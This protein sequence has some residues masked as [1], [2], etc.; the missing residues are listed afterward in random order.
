M[1]NEP[2]KL[3]GQVNSV[4]GSVEA[5]AGAV[6]EA[7]FQAVGG[8]TEP[9]V[10]TKDGK[11]R[12]D[13]GE[14]EIKAAEAKQYAEGTVDRVVGKKDAIV[15]AITG[16]SAQELSGNAQKESGHAQQKLATS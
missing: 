13:K 12:H 7:G 15:G 14:A 16:D 6:I 2:S 10:L 4:V 1:S 9:S 5:M 8:S 11:E 3:N